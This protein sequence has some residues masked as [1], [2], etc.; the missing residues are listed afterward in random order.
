MAEAGPG[1]SHLG[2]LKPN[3][4]LE[5]S[6]ENEASQLCIDHRIGAVVRWKHLGA[7]EVIDQALGN[8]SVA[9]L[10]NWVSD[11]RRRTLDLVA[12]L[13][14]AQLM[15]AKLDIVNPLLW[16]IGHIAWFHEKWVLRH[17]LGRPSIRSDSDTLW[18]SMAIAHDTRW[19][20]P[21][22]TREETIDYMGRVNDAILETLVTQEPTPDLL[23]HARYAA[24]HED[25][26]GEA[27]TYTRQTHGYAAPSLTGMTSDGFAQG[28]P[29]IGDVQ[30]AV[31]EF[32]LGA[33]DDGRFAF[34]NEKWAHEVRLEPFDI[35]KAPVAQGEFAAFVD[36]GGYSR[37][38]LWTADG[39]EW[40]ESAAVEH[41][42]YWRSQ[43]PGFWERRVFDRWVELEQHKPV[44]HV[45]WHEAL[46][47]CRWANRRL[48]TEAEWEAAATLMPNG[49]T[50][51]RRFPWGEVSPD[52]SR[53][54]LDSVVLSCVDVG[55]C[56]AGDSEMGCR[57]MVG[58]VWEWTSSD[59]E[60]YPG[61]S[62]D[63]YEAYSEPWFH[64]RKVLRGGC[65]ASR[66]RMLSSTYR[67]FYEPHRCDVLAGFRT[68]ALQD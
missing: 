44:I 33:K 34:D 58:N 12:D 14:D 37:Q 67:N 7:T 62:P 11:A 60:P 40:R 61:F 9:E 45:N 46:A 57:Q 28:G 32:L 26:H 42:V 68:C 16:E 21:L 24:H 56:S 39:W 18:D 5:A 36:D 66:G 43:A 47:Y 10:A 52:P 23:Y 64:T 1:R 50:E 53:A 31:D 15:G 49:A 59:F 51:K 19:D 29:C 65:W 6:H 25:M 55:A 48:P 54:N 17:V 2:S 41:P 27:F 20:L 3:S 22:P 8:P 35:A 13:S 4:Y 63:P 30:L 38:D